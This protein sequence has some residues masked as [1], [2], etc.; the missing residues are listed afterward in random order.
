[1]ERSVLREVEKMDLLVDGFNMS[2][3]GYVINKSLREMN[4]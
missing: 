4:T 1:M 2:E 3:Q